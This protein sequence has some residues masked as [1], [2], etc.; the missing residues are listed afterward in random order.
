ME[1][2]LGNGYQVINHTAAISIRM[3]I[4]PGQV[5]CGESKS[6][7][8]AVDPCWVFLYQVFHQIQPTPSCNVVESIPAILL[9]DESISICF[10]HQELDNFLMAFPCSQVDGC[11][12]LVI[13]GVDTCWV[14]FDK[15][16]DDIQVSI[17]C[18]NV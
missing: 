5:K 16:F 7:V 14:V 9:L 8:S 3:A 2:K 1:W 12:F 15:V 13:C 17:L 4:F 6:V 10:F 11:F 18:T